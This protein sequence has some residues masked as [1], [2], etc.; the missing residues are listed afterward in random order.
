MKRSEYVESLIKGGISPERA[1]E[2]AKGAFGDADPAFDAVDAALDAMEKGSQKP[3]FEDDDEDDDDSEDG[4]EDGSYDDDDEDYVVPTKAK[5]AMK[6]LVLDAVREVIEPLIGALDEQVEMAK[7]QRDAQGAAFGTH[8][9]QSLDALRGLTAAVK[10]LGAKFDAVATRVE[11]MEKGLKEP[12]PPKGK[13]GE[14]VI[15]PH[16]SEQKREG[17]DGSAAPMAKGADWKAGVLTQARRLGERGV[18]V[19]RVIERG[20]SVEAIS[21]AATAAGITV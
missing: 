7:G 19:C 8:L 2:L 14:V 3:M 11:S 21:A 16:P 9:G 5:A 17:A 13:P 12:L 10:D 1:E 4:S 6:G 18:E 15:L 20:G